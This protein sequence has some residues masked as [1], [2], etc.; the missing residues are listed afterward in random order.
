MKLLSV[1]WRSFFIQALFNAER[2]QNLGLRFAL[3]GV[4]PRRSLEK[5]NTFFNIQP[6][7]AGFVLGLALALEEED[8]RDPESAQRIQSLK[9]SLS[10][11]LAALGDSL[12]WGVWRPACA[13]AAVGLYALGLPI[14][15]VCAF[16]LTL[17]NGLCLAVRW[18]GLVWGYRWRE[19]IAEK[20]RQISWQGWIKKL[21]WGGFVLSLAL[22]LDFIVEGSLP[23]WISV[24]SVAAF[25]EL[26]RRD[27]SALDCCLC[28][29]LAAA[30]YYW[31]RLIAL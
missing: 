12:L 4:L 29:W 30:A 25:F 26:K 16:Y 31:M 15:A 6:Y 11:A 17:Y 20:L 3:E 22:A 27:F 1:F 28:L 14:L 2:M 19:R 8:G 23:F 13:A 18:K 10:S 9:L 7:M 21:R 5:H 24:P